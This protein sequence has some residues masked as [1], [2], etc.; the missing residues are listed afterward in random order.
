MNQMQQIFREIPD[1]I[2]ILDAYGYI[3]DFNR[4]ISLPGL[5]RGL[6]IDRFIP[7][8]LTRPEEAIRLNGRMFDFRRTA[9]YKDRTI[10]GYTISLIDI[11]S[12][13]DLLERSAETSRE[14]DRLIGQRREANEALRKYAHKVRQLSEYTE[15]LRIAQS[16]H[17]KAGHAVTAIHA[18]CRMG[19]QMRTSDPKEF[20]A[21]MQEGIRICKEATAEERP[22]VYSSMRAL[23][24]A[25]R[26]DCQIP[27]KISLREE[28]GAPDAS[29]QEVILQ[30]L[31]EAYHNT[32]DHSL[33]ETML[34]EA[35]VTP[36]GIGLHISDDGAFYGKLEKGFGLRSMEEAVRQH[37]GSIR[38]DTHQETTGEDDA[39]ANASDRHRPDFVWNET[40]QMQGLRIHVFLP[41]K[42]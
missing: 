2:I 28:G 24:E 19:L 38:F 41:Q 42:I 6:S 30:I 26:H 35:D 39:D 11:T 12:E 18:I 31:R 8:C 32:L 20:S 22:I 10:T 13:M 34:I 36:R 29:L 3:L 14:L 1:T 17:D 33:A 16:I 15:Q 5:K 40:R 37:G 25:F 23:L 21:L 4:R 7:D 9:L 27:V